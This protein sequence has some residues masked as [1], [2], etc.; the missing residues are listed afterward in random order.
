MTSRRPLGLKVSCLCLV[1]SLGCTTEQC[2][3]VSDD[4]NGD[5]ATRP[6]QTVAPKAAAAPP[7]PVPVDQATALRLLR[8][9]DPMNVQ[10]GAA[11][12]AVRC[13]THGASDASTQRLTARAS[14]LAPENASLTTWTSLAQAIVHCASDS[15][16]QRIEA[17]LR[18]W[19]ELDDPQAQAAARALAAR[20]ARLR[21]LDTTTTL[22]LLQRSGRWPNEVWFALSQLNLRAVSLRE[23]IISAAKQ[24][25]SQG[26]AETQHIIASLART[27]PDS[28]ELLA[29]V[30]SSR[31]AEAIRL[32][33]VAAL[34][35]AGP[36][37]QTQ[38]AG[39]LKRGS[40]GRSPAFNETLVR[41]LGEKT[42][43]AQPE[44]IAALREILV[45]TQGDPQPDAARLNCA[46]SAA[47][48]VAT[49]Q[50]LPLLECDPHI[51]R[52][53][54]LANLQRLASAK[55]RP[56][57]QGQWR[58][59]LESSDPLVRQEALKQLVRVS[60]QTS[61]SHLVQALSD[62]NAGTVAI[63]A[64]LV[65][66]LADRKP[67]DQRADGL[68]QALK[69]NLER[70]VD[71]DAIGTRVALLQAV[72]ALQALSFKSLLE[73]HCTS[74][75][76]AVRHAAS[77]ALNAI[78]STHRCAPQSHSL[79]AP[80]GGSMSGPRIQLTTQRGEL[81]IDLDPVTAPEHVARITAL[82][83]NGFYDGLTL[84]GGSTLQLGDGDG[85]GFANGDHE[86]LRSEISPSPFT[87]LSVGMAQT[88]LDSGSTQFFVNRYDRPDLDLRYPYLGA[89]SPSWLEARPG[90]VVTRAIIVERKPTQPP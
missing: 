47:L 15:D 17:Q 90:D 46:A 11:M 81:W 37:G 58:R 69:S 89:A 41:A 32:S 61:E 57:Q 85:D 54:L 42:I 52:H 9:A 88:G 86:P 77:A 84:T 70:P 22:A 60:P 16:G 8:S 73:A 48:S 7:I 5:I 3:P 66:D 74:T 38:L 71:N 65:R 43:R 31:Q 82:A 35:E 36:Q 83:R 62:K 4:E 68:L 26:Q 18:D 75:F 72:A 1:A 12:I 29:E 78:N 63:A 2:S 53:G 23:R 76:S 59:L 87:S 55:F 27:T 39:W 20:A 50:A 79:I 24:A 33:A 28:V 6:N 19:L 56:A 64:R 44:A 67:I 45:R 51:R 30:A 25:L 21:S 10:R 13:R 34:G 49:K 14:A 80:A 40:Q